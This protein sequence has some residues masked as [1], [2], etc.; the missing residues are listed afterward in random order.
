M[1]FAEEVLVNVLALDR[2]FKDFEFLHVSLAPA[3]LRGRAS[4]IRPARAL[5]RL[6]ELYEQVDASGLSDEAP[7]FRRTYAQDF[8]RCVIAQAETFVCAKRRD[9]A[10]T[11]SRLMAAPILEPFDLEQELAE[12]QALLRRQGFKSVAEFNLSKRK[13]SFSSRNR[14][15]DY[16]LGFVDEVAAKLSSRCGKVFGCDLKAL[17]SSSKLRITAPKKGDPPCFYRYE[18]RGRGSL[19]IALQTEFSENFLR[20]FI[21]HEAVPGHHL[22]YLLKQQRVDRGRTDA[23][24]LVDTYY[25]PE[26]VV[27]EGLAVNADRLYGQVLDDSSQLSAQV[28][29]FLHRVFYN[30][31]HRRNIERRPFEALALRILR[32]FMG[33]SE[34]RIAGQLRYHVR[35]ARYYSP[36]YPLGIRLVERL[37]KGLA[38]AELPALYAQQS[39]STLKKWQKSKAA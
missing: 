36:V 10:Q 39:V 16:V 7:R 25:S 33:H 11:V 24:D 35:E 23:I 38:L 9:F 30:C 32:R 28:E 14:L 18:G 34:A 17:I 3:R 27:N 37:A 22:Y 26:N 5:A 13:L 6:R 29:K 20:N 1:T 19:G 8:L 12:L 4:R 2:A 31:W 21:S 15:A